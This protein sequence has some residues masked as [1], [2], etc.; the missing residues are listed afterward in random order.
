MASWFW[1]LADPVTAVAPHAPQVPGGLFMELAGARSRK[2][3]VVNDPSTSDSAAFTIS[4]HDPEA[5]FVTELESDLVVRRDDRVLFRGRVGDSGDTL[6]AGRHDASFTGM[7]YRE[8]LKRRS[9]VSASTLSYTSLDEMLITWALMD[10]AQSQA[11]GNLGVSRGAGAAGSGIVRSVTYNKTDYVFDNISALAQMD[12]GFDWN[13]TPHGANASD[14]RLDL[15]AGGL[16][17]QT[18]VVLQWGDGIVASC[19]RSFDPTAFANRLYVT[20]DSSASLTPVA[21]DNGILGSDPRGRWESVVATTEVVQ[22]TLAARAANLLMNYSQELA[23]WQLVLR[24]GAWGG[25]DHIWPGD[26]LTWQVRS[27]RLAEDTQYR[28]SQLDVVPNDNGSE[29]VTVTLGRL[30]QDIRE[31]IKKIKRRVGPL[32]APAPVP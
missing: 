17:R 14:L 8:L 12:N 21:L 13:I 11:G 3:T 9:L 2:L 29:Q 24:Q 19:T 10:Y 16:Q 15:Y 1:G 4:G 20:G 26:V 7:S 31:I 27:G 32:H 23:S 28:V 5:A 18:G 22:A 30:R 6:D 25:P